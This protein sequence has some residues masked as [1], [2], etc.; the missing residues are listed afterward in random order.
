MNPRED[1]MA[2]EHEPE[3]RSAE[4]EHDGLKTT[5]YV[6][7]TRDPLNQLLRVTTRFARNGP[8]GA[9]PDEL[10]TFTLRWFRRDELVSLLHNA[11]F[12]DVAIYGD[13]GRRPLSSNSPAMVVLA[14]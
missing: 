12:N 10:V 7:V 6:R 8:N 2:K 4:F 5:R 14:R 11:G 3:W 9:L 13:F 1:E